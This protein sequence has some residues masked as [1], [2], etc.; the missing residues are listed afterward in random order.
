AQTSDP[1]VRIEVSGGVRVIPIS[2]SGYKEDAASV[3]R[4]DLEVAGFEITDAEKAQYTLTGKNDGGQIEGRLQDR[5]SKAHLLAKAYTGENVRLQAHALADDVVLAITKVP[6][7]ARTKVVFK[8]E[9][10]QGNSEIYISDYDG[11]NAKPVTTDNSIVAA[12]SFFPKKWHLFYTSYRSGFPWIYSHNLTDGERRPFAKFAG[13]NSGGVVSP[14]GT[15]VAMILSKAGSPDV[16]VANIDGTNLRQLT[17]TREDESS[18]CWSPDGTKI[19]FA[20]RVNERRSLLIIPAAGG[21][22]VRLNT[23]GEP[24]PSEPDWAP[25]GK[26][27]V[28]TSQPRAGFNICTVPAQGGP[29]QLLV[30][31]EDPSWAPN[32]RTVI[33]TKRSG[34]KRT[35][36]L[37]DVPT[38]RVKDTAQ[39]SGSRSQP[40]WAK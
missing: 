16:W 5:L 33:F 7:I 3:L 19:C 18:P 17:K 22:A 13:L 24:N 14:D 8:H 27:I 25:D 23:G 9:K 35:L 2:L 38:K 26:T 12:P 37:L 6:G 39:I 36:S 29:V 1:N 32:S 20:S 21:Q 34:N 11:H 15:R 10:S 28:F 30:A 4:F 40:S 31:G